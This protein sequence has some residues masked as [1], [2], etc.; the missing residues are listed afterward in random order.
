MSESKKDYPVGYRKPPRHSQFRPGTSGNP[1]GRKRGSLNLKT[2]LES[3]LKESIRIREGERE[4]SVSKQRAMIKALLAKALKGDAR[5]AS[6]L[7]GLI[8]KH[9]E[10]ELASDTSKPLASDDL[11]IL[12]AYVARHAKGA[13]E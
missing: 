4:F 1:K 7:I 11:K 10:S 5:A 8:A 9:I 6:L 2:D 13:A 3:E 12:E